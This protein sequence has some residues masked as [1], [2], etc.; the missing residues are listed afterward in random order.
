[1]ALGLQDRPWLVHFKDVS[2]LTGF[3]ATVR[4]SL[5]RREQRHVL[6]QGAL[7][8]LNKLTHARVQPADKPTATAVAA[9]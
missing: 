3:R 9:C 8:K 2:R 4:H 6:P 7:P 1:M 5:G